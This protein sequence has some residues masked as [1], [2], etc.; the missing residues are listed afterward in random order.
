MAWRL[1]ARVFITNGPW[2]AFGSGTV[3]MRFRGASRADFAAGL[4]V[5]VGA[6]FGCASPA[7]LPLAMATELDGLAAERPTAILFSLAGCR[8][9]DI[10]ERGFVAAARELG[11]AAHV[12]KLMVTPDNQRLLRTRFGIHGTP[13]ARLLLAD[14]RAEKLPLTREGPLVAAAVREKSTAPLLRRTTLTP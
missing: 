3:Q 4:A 12:R 13:D 8:Y 9:C 14:G 7:R 2:R 5:L 10:A 11:A 6:A 1:S